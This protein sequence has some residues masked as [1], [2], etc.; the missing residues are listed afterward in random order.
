M[1]EQDKARLDAQME[2]LCE[3]DRL[4]AVSRATRLHDNSRYENSAE[5]SWHIAVY[6]M[7]LADRAPEGCDVNKV[8][9]M[10]LIHD[11]VEIDAGDNP[12]HGDFDAEAMAEQEQAAADRLF[13]LLP[14]DQAKAFRDLW[15]EFEAAETPEARFAKGLDRIP[16]PLANMS[17]GGGSWTEYNVSIDDL[18]R[19]VGHP[20]QRGA[21]ALWAWLRPNIVQ[22]F[23]SKS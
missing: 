16:A 20:I 4:K 15:D 12:I 21:P 1:N 11:I 18:D 22:W 6:A 10:L 23:A 13:G 19:R 9:R 7:V 2:F 14:E 17:N 8:I 3:V 5:H